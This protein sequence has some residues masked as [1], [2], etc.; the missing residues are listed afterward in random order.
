[1]NAARWLTT[2]VLVAPYVG[3][4]AWGEPSY[5]PAVRVP[6]RVEWTSEVQQDGENERSVTTAVVLTAAP[7]KPKDRVWLPSLALEAPPDSAASDATKA[8]TVD[9][10]TAA[11]RVSGRVA[12]YE[13]RF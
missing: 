8:R 4:S 1:M 13:T 9:S 5:G 12:F 3:V 10:C 2:S 6:A 11:P 7:L